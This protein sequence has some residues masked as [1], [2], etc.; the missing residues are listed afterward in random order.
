MPF[1]LRHELSLDSSVIIQ[2]LFYMLSLVW[3]TTACSRASYIHLWRFINTYWSLFFGHLGVGNRRILSLSQ[4]T[5]TR[6]RRRF[7]YC[8]TYQR[9]C[10]DTKIS[11]LLV[12]SPWNPWFPIKD[13]PLKYNIYDPLTCTQVFNGLSRILKATPLREPTLMG[14]ICTMSCRNM[15][16][17]RKT[18]FHERTRTCVEDA[19]PEKKHS[20]ASERQGY[21]ADQ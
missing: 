5:A 4:S 2:Y 12:A 15:G 6:S 3:V 14:R 21:E 18:R 1:M 11:P 13:T 8:D 7:K 16:K 17:S 19:A 20:H 9:S 10:Y